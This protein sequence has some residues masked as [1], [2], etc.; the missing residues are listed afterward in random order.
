MGEDRIKVVRDEYVQ[1][2]TLHAMSVLGHII[3][4]EGH[5]SATIGVEKG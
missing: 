4:D 1:S 3:A 2:D 5:R